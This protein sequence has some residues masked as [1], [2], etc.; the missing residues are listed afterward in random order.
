MSR[1]EIEKCSKDPSKKLKLLKKLDEVDVKER[2]K[3]KYTPLSNDK[4]DQ[5]QYYGYAKMP[6]S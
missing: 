2:K 3:P 6:L 4:T 5:M 1:E